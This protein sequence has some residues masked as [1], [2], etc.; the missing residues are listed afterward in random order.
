[1]IRR[2]L[3]VLA[4]LTILF[5]TAPAGAVKSTPKSGAQPKLAPAASFERPNPKD[6]LREAKELWH[7][8]ADY[9]GAL[10]KFNDAVDAEPKD[11][12]TRLQRAHFFEML[13]AIVV[14]EDKAEFKAR[15]RMDYE[16]I[17]AD[18]PDSVIAGMARDGLT[19]LA[20]EPVI[21]VKRVACPEAAV[22]SRARADALYGARKYAEAVAEYA[23]ATDG[24]PGDAAS[25]VDFADSY[26][27][28][29]DYG[30]AKELFAK[31]L[32]VDPWNREAH[33]YLSDTEI[34][35]KNLEVAGHQL[36]LAV[37]SD[38]TYEAGWSALR[39]YAT[40]LGR[41][42]NRVYGDRRPEAGNADGASW[43]AYGEAKAGARGA[44]PE[45]ASALA[46][47]REAVKA[48]LRSQKGSGP[49]WSMMARAEQAGYLDEAIF[50]HM[51]D[52]ELAAEY[53]TFRDVNADR[54]AS[55]LETM[56]VGEAPAPGP[57]AENGG[58]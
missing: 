23:K 5:L 17:A 33:R 19:R 20:G 4:I 10:A 31:A 32:S 42:W 56:I 6:L 30:K 34:Q 45:L 49:F 38:P 48:A 37:V 1:M 35:L 13:A 44:H 47:E 36:V 55:Y 43:A 18:D 3:P 14:A 46:I 8:K 41:K 50:I 40:A 21:E 9:T 7:M 22:Q 54:L 58:S 28:L 24:C 52:A 39:T 29:E 27:V 25:W 15:A 12:D 53:Q 16:H 2:M 11:N 26:Y 57:E 51:L